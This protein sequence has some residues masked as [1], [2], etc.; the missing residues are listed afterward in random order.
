[1]RRLLPATGLLLTGL[2]AQQDAVEVL[3][4]DYCIS[5]HGEGEVSGGLDLTKPADGQVA[6]LWRWSRIR[7]RVRTFEMPPA[8]GDGMTVEERRQVTEFVDRLLDREVPSLP[9][10]SDP[11]TVRRL[12]RYQWRN[13]VFDLFG[14]DQDVDQFPVDDLGYGFDSI[15]EA[16]TF[17]T[18]HLEKYLAAST[19]VAAEVFH[20]EDPAAPAR[21][22]FAGGGM[23]LRGARGATMGRSAHMYTNAT[24]EQ[25][26]ESP[27]DGVYR[28]RIVASAQQVGDEPAHM[29]PAID[30]A[31]LE[32]IEV[33]NEDAQE[34]SVE[35]RLSGGQHEVAVSFI[36]DYYDPDAPDG[37]RRDRNL[38]IESVM[39]EGPVD[40]RV[41]PAQVGWLEDALVGGG[42]DDVA[43]LRLLVE[44]ILPRLWRREALAA[45][46]DRLVQAGARLVEDGE[47]LLEAQR[48]ILAAALTSPH[49]LF[50]T[51]RRR[52]DAAVRGFE[53]ATRL[54]Y[55]IWA[56]APDE[57]LLERAALGD[58]QRRAVVVAE[59]DRML[60]DERADRLATD[61]AGQWLEL[62][63]LAT[64]R[65]DPD[66]FPLDDAL[67]A[68]L[69]RETELLF[70]AI[71]RE[72]RDVRELVDVD[73]T[74]V[75]ARLA[76]HY[77]LPHEGDPDAFVRTT[78]PVA[79]RA[80]GGILGHGSVLAVTS[81]PTRTSPVKR[82]KWILDNLL[83]QSP[84]PPP[85]GNDSF[86]DEAAIDGSATL[87][88]QMAQHRERADCA[89]CHV[90][91][92][93]LGLSL[94]RFD[95]VGRYRATDKDGVIDASSQLPDG[96]ALAGL[97]DLKRVIAADPAFVRT[98]AHKLFVYAV[99]RDLRPVDRLRIDHAVTQLL[100]AGE[101][102]LRDLIHLVVRDPAFR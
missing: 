41:A 77:G 95:A 6:K 53:L 64:T 69:S 62:R 86:G 75:D 28:L 57:A 4:E 23:R 71:L 56:S 27:R 5:C 29:R 63:S 20:G 70:A 91:M 18:I 96:S 78:L 30:G 21:R 94:E 24:I 81:N 54:S 92:D 99:G 34:F 38:D 85:P 33:P 16:L 101:V 35:V 37:R 97:A 15:G 50:R 67:R 25:A 82:G 68:S 65:L 10:E 80:R 45:E 22:T 14:V 52:R 93:A 87:R 46:V 2:A 100:A 79:A 98:V 13:T 3:V 43:Q 17:S 32:T 12:S 44:A 58:L 1:M 7:E 74:H 40:P 73:F 39:I 19:S 26:F 48:F 84:P 36:N 76:A 102:T 60:L 61:F 83:G 11:V 90:R 59:V 88:D 42:D 55:F 31:P 9:A 8:H 72:Q 49:F 51:E 47:D 66:R 89:V